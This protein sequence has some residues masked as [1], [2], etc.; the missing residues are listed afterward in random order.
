MTK[1]N[2][3]QECKVGLTQKINVNHQIHKMK[4]KN[5]I[6]IS[7]NGEEKAFEKN[8]MPIHNKNS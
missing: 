5:H 7:I 3:S 2:L 8:S 1:K 4:E 6:I